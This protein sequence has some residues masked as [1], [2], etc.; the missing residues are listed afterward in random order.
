MMRNLPRL[1]RRGWKGVWWGE[2]SDS[3]YD[4]D[5][6]G[7][8]AGD[9]RGRMAPPPPGNANL[10]MG[11]ESPLAFPLRLSFPSLSRATRQMARQPAGGD[12]ELN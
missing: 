7:T 11:V 8:F 2:D 12:S 5:G 1:A 4:D 10:L 3:D 9:V 6:D